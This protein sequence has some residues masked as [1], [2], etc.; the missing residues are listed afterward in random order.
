MPPPGT[1]HSGGELLEYLVEQASGSRVIRA[2]GIQADSELAF[3]GLALAGAVDRQLLGERHRVLLGGEGV[4]DVLAQGEG[5]DAEVAVLGEVGVERV[6][7]LP[8]FVAATRHRQHAHR[9]ARVRLG[10]AQQLQEGPLLRTYSIQDTGGTAKS[11]AAG[12]ATVVSLLALTRLWGL[13]VSVRNL[14]ERRGND[15]LASLV[16]RS[17]DVVV[18]QMST[19]WLLAQCH[20][21]YRRVLLCAE[22]CTPWGTVEVCSTHSIAANLIGWSSAIARTAPN[23]EST[24]R[25]NVPA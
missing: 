16:E 21:F 22:V 9:L 4:G 23:G 15:R 6:E 13:A 17:S 11:I 18:L 5:E 8:R 3:A 10:G 14:T 7:K 1:T 24:I 12:I 20:E 25:S 19:T 2:T